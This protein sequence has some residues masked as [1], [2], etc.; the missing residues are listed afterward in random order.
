MIFRQQISE[1]ER[2]NEIEKQKIKEKLEIKFHR[3]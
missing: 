3:A 1:I 2:Q